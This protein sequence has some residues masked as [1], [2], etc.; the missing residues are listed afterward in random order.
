MSTIGDTI[1][2]LRKKEGMTV[3]TLSLL[4]GLTE[5][6]IHYIEKDK[7]KPSYRSLTKIA[8]AC[9]RNMIIKYSG[10][11]KIT[12]VYFPIRE[13]KRV[14]DL[15]EKIAELRD[16]VF[17]D[18][19]KKLCHYSDRAKAEDITQE[20]MYQAFVYS[21]RYNRDSL[22]LYSWVYEIAKN[23]FK[24]GQKQIGVHN[25]Y[26]ESVKDY[27]DMGIEPKDIEERKSVLQAVNFLS[28][29]SKELFKLKTL[30]YSYKEIGKRLGTKDTSAKSKY[31]K[32]RKQ[33]V[34][35]YN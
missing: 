27:L 13:D 30:G 32:I 16:R 12:N 23:V 14:K 15:D 4:S 35:L 3:Q 8:D 21:H 28:D 25:R 26:F 17:Q 10:A 24:N 31:W 29:D 6:F 9:D 34:E 2:T 18:V 19:F 5:R 11:K 22:Q 20:T 33:L 7:K 1:R